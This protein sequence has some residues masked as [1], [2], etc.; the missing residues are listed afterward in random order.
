MSTSIS[1]FSASGPSFSADVLS[2]SSSGPPEGTA[3]ESSAASSAFAQAFAQ[4]LADLAAQ[5]RAQDRDTAQSAD[6]A[7][8]RQE[9][10]AE[11]DALSARDSRL[12]KLAGLENTDGSAEGG[13]DGAQRVLSD[14]ALVGQTGPTD[15]T[16]PLLTGLDAGARDA[17]AAAA[18]AAATSASS[19]TPSWAAGLTTVAVSPGL[20]VIQPAQSELDGQSL[21]AF[22]RAQGLDDRAVQWLFGSQG[23]QATARSTATAAGLAEVLEG[24]T[25]LPGQ[26]G[27]PLQTQTSLQVQTQFQ[28][29]VASLSSAP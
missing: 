22:A 21:V 20:N 28:A 8:R 7:A 12:A 5:R 25:T 9:V 6:D 15:P 18:A 16:D 24:A 10:A 3:G 14:T 27:V 13:T 1:D 19:A 11:S 2:G 26:P 17:Q 29:Q 4:K 23:S